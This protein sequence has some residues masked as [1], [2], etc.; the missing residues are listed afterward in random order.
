MSAEDT[1]PGLGYL[2]RTARVGYVA[3]F[4][5]LVVSFS[6][7]MRADRRLVQMLMPQAAVYALIGFTICIAVAASSRRPMAAGDVVRVACWTLIAGAEGFREMGF[8][9]YVRGEYVVPVNVGAVSLMVLALGAIVYSYHRWPPHPPAPR[10]PRGG[11]CGECGYLLAGLP[12]PRCPECGTRFD[13][14]DPNAR[15]HG[16]ATSQGSPL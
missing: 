12:E 3:L 2:W 10:P 1:Q 6:L 15:A 14:R 5:L 13:P 4:L 8:G 9:Y 16:D 7:D 11:R